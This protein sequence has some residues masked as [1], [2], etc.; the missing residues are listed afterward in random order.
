[1]PLTRV[2]AHL[3]PLNMEADMTAMLSGSFWNPWRILG[4][5]LAASLVLAPAVAMQFTDEVRWGPL[6]FTFA[7]TLIGGVGL[8]LEWSLR[9][10]ADLAY[11]A[12]A[13]TALLAVF[14]QTW[15]NGAVGV[16]GNEGNPANLMVGGVLA[17]ALV[18]AALARL[19]AHGLARAMFA[20]MTAQLVL[21]VVVIVAGLD[22][23]A[24]PLCLFFAVLWLLSGLLFARAARN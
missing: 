4:W 21:L 13:A 24:V 14:L 19:R 7:I 9:R 5:G 20:A 6:D 3:R 22:L 10:S 16:V 11:R 15:I 2:S 23:K 12:G 8:A 1:M 18:G 17:V